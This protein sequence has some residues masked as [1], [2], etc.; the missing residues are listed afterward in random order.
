MPV[1]STVVLD[2]YETWYKI[3]TDEAGP[4]SDG[5]CA[6]LCGAKHADT[7]AE[8]RAVTPEECEIWAE[9]HREAIM[10]GAEDLAEHRDQREGEEAG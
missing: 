3:P 10:H 9:E 6:V 2:L 5:Q 8:V 7:R 1:W 4:T